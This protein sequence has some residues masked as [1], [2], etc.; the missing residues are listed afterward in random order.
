M[1]RTGRSAPKGASHEVQ[2]PPNHQAHGRSAWHLPRSRCPPR[3]PSRS[4]PARSTSRLTSNQSS[5]IVR[6]VESGGGFR[7]GRCRHRRRRRPR[8]RCSSAPAGRSSSRTVGP[9]TP[10][11]DGPPRRADL[12]E[13][14]RAS[15]AR[16]APSPRADAVIHKIKHVVVIMQ[17]NRSF[18]SY[19]GTY[20]GADGIPMQNG[21]PTVCVP[22]PP[23]AAAS[24]V[25]RPERRQRRRPARPDERGRRHRRRQDG[26]LR[27][28]GRAGAQK[29]CVNATNPNCANGAGR[30]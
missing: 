22:D 28:A 27:R 24:P 26:R 11:A 21:V 17:E 8:G 5:P 9:R 14:R 12:P 19:F 20:P 23:T 4:T 29:G 13:D 18:D 7:L 30:T 25:P 2:C 1:D 15:P 10:A 16:A 6:T 3:R